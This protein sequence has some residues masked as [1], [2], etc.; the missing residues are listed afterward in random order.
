ML[1]ILFLGTGEIGVP[2][3]Q[4]LSTS[5]ALEI[6]GVVTQPDRPAGRHLKLQPSPIKAAAMDLGLKVYQPEKLRAPEALADVSGLNADLFVVVAYGQILS[7]ATLALPRLGCINVH[8][9]LLPKY[10]GASPIH[11]AI[12]NGD[13]ESGVT[14]MQMD[15][16]LDTGDI[17][18]QSA[19]AILPEDTAGALHDRLARLAPVP[20]LRVISQLADNSASRIPQDDSLATYAPKITKSQGSLDWSRSAA[21]LERQVRAFHPWPGSF[22]RLEDGST[23]KIHAACLTEGSGP[24][25]TVLESSRHPFTVAT[26]DGA[27]ALLSVQLAGGRPLDSATFLRGHGV[28]P[29]SKLSTLSKS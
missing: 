12:L 6:C 18:Y 7:K 13:P 23:L 10:R 25:G 20:L 8:A 2:S 19:C 4:A 11:A 27:L 3:L 14:I 29:G 1:K 15:E 5:G 28:P 21:E 9:S 16:G 26:S 17:L 22:T 24:P